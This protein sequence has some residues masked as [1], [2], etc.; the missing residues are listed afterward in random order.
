MQ[1]LFG[2]PRDG[3]TTSRG[4]PAFTPRGTLVALSEA[5]GNNTAAIALGKP[6]QKQSGVAEET[7]I[8]DA[9]VNMDYAK[10]WV[11]KIFETPRGDHSQKKSEAF[12]WLH[13]TFGMVKAGGDENR[14]PA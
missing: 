3:S 4:G 7:H 6:L 14:P 12:K 10:E 5:S 8:D 1:L 9:A 13:E 2:S 11:Q